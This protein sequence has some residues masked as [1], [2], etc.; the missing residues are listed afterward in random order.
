MSGGGRVHLNFHQRSVFAEDGQRALKIS[1]IFLRGHEEEIAH[2]KIGR[3][4]GVAT[5]AVTL[6][7]ASEIESRFLKKAILQIEARLVDF[8]F[9]MSE[10]GAKN[11]RRHAGVQILADLKSYLDFFFQWRGDVFGDDIFGF[12]G[13]GEGLEIGNIH[14]GTIGTRDAFV[15]E[16]FGK[17]DGRETRRLRNA[18]RG[19]GCGR[20]ERQRSGDGHDAGAIGICFVGGVVK[21]GPGAGF[22]G[23]GLIDKGDV[24]GLR[25]RISGRPDRL[26]F[27]PEQ[28]L[29]R[30]RCR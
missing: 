15:L 28:R 12:V 30:S 27:C 4:E 1:K 3:V 18:V 8:L 23:G 16:S 6:R 10:Q 21:G 26:P 29:R 9:G 11:E 14:G 5:G 19:H 20:I 25:G 7:G 13:G 2:D 24:T 17:R 22:A